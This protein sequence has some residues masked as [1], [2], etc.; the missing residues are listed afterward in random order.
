MIENKELLVET[1]NSVCTLTLNRPE[2]RNSLTRETL[3]LL[4]DEIRR[5]AKN[6]EVRCR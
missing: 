4:R 3:E 6:P 5:L 1:E 2:K